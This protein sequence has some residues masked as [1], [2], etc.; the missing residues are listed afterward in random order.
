MAQATRTLDAA[1]AI[2]VHAFAEGTF[3][4]WAV[5]YLHETKKLSETVAAL[6]FSGGDG[7]G[8]A[9]GVA[10]CVYASRPNGCGRYCQC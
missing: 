10:D 9:A 6:A 7:R 2:P 8:Q 4:N 3:A 1:A 5:I